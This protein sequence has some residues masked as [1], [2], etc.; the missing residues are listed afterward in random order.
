[1]YENE[2]HF[3]DVNEKMHLQEDKRL[4]F[5]ALYSERYRSY[6]LR[7]GEAIVEFFEVTAKPAV[8][9]QPQKRVF[10]D[11]EEHNARIVHSIL[12]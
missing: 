10:I 7:R 1:L 2:I 8:L 12:K 5:R 6:R 3:K 9:Y 4:M 11:K